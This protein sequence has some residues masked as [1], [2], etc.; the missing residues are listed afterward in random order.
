MAANAITSNLFAQVG[1][2]GQRFILFDE[3]IDHR[4]DG[5]EIKE[6]DAFIH[7]AMVTSKGVRPP[8]NGKCV[9]NG[10]TVV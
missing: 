3:I 6:E 5:T 7:M 8:K 9:Y 4:T 1:Q 2:D 10:R